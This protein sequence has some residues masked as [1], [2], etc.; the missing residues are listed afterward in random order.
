MNRAINFVFLSIFLLATAG[1]HAVQTANTPALTN[2]PSPMPTNT[3][4]T[5]TFQPQDGERTLKVNNLE[6]TYLIHIPSGLIQT[7][8]IPLMFVFHGLSENAA[9]IKQA[10]GMD[11]TA[12]AHQFIVVY[13]NGSGPEGGQSWNAGPCCGYAFE[14][15]VDDLEF[16]RQIIADVSTLAKV[17][18]KQ[19][20]A[21][22]FSNGALFTYRLACEMSDTF[23][24][25]APLAGVMLN[26]PCAPSQPVSIIHFHGLVDNLVPISG[27]GI[28]PST[29]KPF[30]GAE[31]SV[32]AWAKLDGCT[33]TPNTEETPVF[34]HVTY[35]GCKN[36]TA[37]E[38]YAI[39]G[40]GHSWPS[41]YIVQA[42]ELIWQF[43]QSHPKP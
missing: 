1:C 40:V 16:I 2:T 22:G 37:V 14:H 24:S 15:Q 28:I 23:A 39:K 31:E 27:G 19:I 6:R 7:E 4:L 8:Q 36:S 42:D 10:S 32:A 26:D 35:S 34:T 41:Q 29:G 18:P 20:Y 25:V 17:D 30:P 33:E 3:A 43:F 11:E 12:N 13:P 21:A 5:A 9:Y 38:F